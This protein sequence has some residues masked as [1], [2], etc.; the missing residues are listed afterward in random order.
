MA[1]EPDQAAW[2]LLLIVFEAILLGVVLG[3]MAETNFRQA[4]RISDGSLMI[5][6]ERPVCAVMLILGLL[7]MIAPLLIRLITKR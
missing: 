1:L 4:L 6:I 2:D 3:G 5:F 7:M